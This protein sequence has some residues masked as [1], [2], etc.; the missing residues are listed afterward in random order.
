MAFVCD[1]DI[2]NDDN[3]DKLDSLVSTKRVLFIP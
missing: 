2:V 1:E 3:E